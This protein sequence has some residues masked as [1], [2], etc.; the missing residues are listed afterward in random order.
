MTLR[1]YRLTAALATW[2]RAE[3]HASQPTR[4]QWIERRLARLRR[5]NH[6]Q[7]QT[8]NSQRETTTTMPTTITPMKGG[9]Q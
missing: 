4:R 7:P 3:L 1:D 8:H 9:A 6:H 5:Q 2:T